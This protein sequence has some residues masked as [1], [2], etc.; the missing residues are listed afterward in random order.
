MAEIEFNA[1]EIPSGS[2]KWRIANSSHQNYSQCATFANSCRAAAGLSRPARV[3]AGFFL[4]AA[5]TDA[6]THRN[7]HGRA[8]ALFARSATERRRVMLTARQSQVNYSQKK[9]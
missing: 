6:S 1:R 2:R 3:C 5:E 7:Q 9:S 8:R 4:C